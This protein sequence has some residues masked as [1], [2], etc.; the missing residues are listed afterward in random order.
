MLQFLKINDFLLFKNQEISFDGNFTV[1]TGETG[2]G[3]SMFIKALRFVLGEKQ[4]LPEMNYSVMA[5]FKL[6]RDNEVLKE[7]L[8]ENDIDIEDNTIILRRSLSLNNKG[9]AFINDVSVTLKLLKKVSDELIEFHSQHKQLDAFSQSNSL[10]II[11]QFIDEKA[12]IIKVA[13]L[14]QQVSKITIEIEARLVEK[15]SLELDKDYIEHSL[16]EIKS[17]NL[18]EGEELELIEKK[19]LFSD[20]VRVV[21]AVEGLLTVFA[22]DEGIINKLIRVQRNLAK[23]ETNIELDDLIENSIFH[24]SE[25][26]NQAENRLKNFDSNESME[27]IEERLSKMKE[28]SRKYRCTTDQL[29]DLVNS[30]QKRLEK[31]ENIDQYIASK[32]LEKN[33]LLEEYFVYA[34]QL[35]DKRSSAAKQL[36]EVILSELKQLKLEQVELNIEVCANQLRPITAKGIDQSKF[37]IKTNKGFEFA[38]I[39]EIASGGELSRM[40]LAFKV[41]LA[42]SN[43]KT[44]IIFDEIDSGTG[45]AVA[46]TIGNRMKKLAQSNQIIAISHQPQ[47]SAKADQHLLVEKSTGIMAETKINN[48]S[49]KERIQEIAKML[50]GIN[51]SD[52]AVSAAIS[53]I[54]G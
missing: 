42:R 1:I 14:Y 22:R 37:M 23:L 27:D 24:L 5:Q 19:K 46:E 21:S 18:K 15:K 25:L 13:D 30:Y 26:Q 32:N 28:L 44:T 38:Q 12:L 41:A 17:L 45:G 29:I 43:Q 48:L 50:S 3:K 10:M 33:K 34:K 52:S 35:S 39:S 2:S 16:K 7:I 31:L 51:V 40:M 54:E 6:G 49:R 8:A 36:E 20:K 4:D 53:L 11:D 9:K 47:V